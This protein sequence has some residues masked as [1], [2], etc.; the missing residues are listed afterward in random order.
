MVYQDHFTK[1][2]ALRPLKNK[3]AFDVAGGLIDILTIFGV[4]V[5][6]QSD[7]GREFR[8]QVIV[9]LKQIWPDMS[10][11]HGRARHP[12]SQGSVE[13]AN[14]DIKKMIATWM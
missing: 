10:F 2:I 5:I 1:F 14:A 8:N 3:S 9:P 12:Q 7:N 13:R 4:P 11:V 6:L